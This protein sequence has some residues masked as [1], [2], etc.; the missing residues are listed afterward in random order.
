[1][2]DAENSDDF[3]KPLVGS[4]RVEKSVKANN[5]YVPQKE[6]SSP[7]KDGSSED[8]EEC[9]SVNTLNSEPKS[10]KSA[11]RN[12]WKHDEVKKLIG[13]RG[14]LN[15]RFQVVKGRMALW[16]EIS[17][18]LLSNGISRSPGQCK[19][20]WTSLLQKY[21]VCLFMSYCMLIL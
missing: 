1:L 16:E 2:S 5:G 8:T 6:N 18:N 11:K 13:M 9:N 7:I 14:E 20:L 21:E 10:S 4:S 3:F 17:Q 15:D 12:K 19:S